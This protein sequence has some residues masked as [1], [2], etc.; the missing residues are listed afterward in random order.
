MRGAGAATATTAASR[1]AGGRS[2]TEARRARE[3]RNPLLAIRGPAAL[4]RERHLALERGGVGGRARGEALERLRG[5]ARERLGREG[6]VELAGGGRVDGHARADARRGAQEAVALG[7]VE[8]DEPPGAGAHQEEGLAEGLRLLLEH[9]PRGRHHRLALE[10]AEAERHQPDARA[11]AP[12]PVLLDQPAPGER[13]QQPVGARLGH[14][15]RAP[16]RGH[17]LRRRA[18]VQVVEQVDRLL[19]RGQGFHRGSASLQGGFQLF[20]YRNM[21]SIV[22]TQPSAR[23]I[24]RRAGRARRC[25]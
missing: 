7:L 14:A 10:G 2:R 3:A 4:A 12:A 5:A 20:R 16:D 13:R 24:S 17:A 8:H 9:G 25:R 19:D 6:E 1:A 11:V 15:Q 18:L 23:R 21:I 22:G